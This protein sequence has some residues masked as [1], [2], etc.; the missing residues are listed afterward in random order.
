VTLT[1]GGG[2]GGGNG[3]GGTTNNGNV[4]N[5]DNR[6]GL[7]GEAAITGVT[8]DLVKNYNFKYYT[9]NGNPGGKGQNGGYTAGYG[10][11]PATLKGFTGAAGGRGGGSGNSNGS[12]G[13]DGWVYIEYYFYDG[14]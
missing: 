1:L 14:E 10:G 5:G 6:G 9:Q 8:S 2:K 4:P 3:P 13:E 11:P 7:P 12:N